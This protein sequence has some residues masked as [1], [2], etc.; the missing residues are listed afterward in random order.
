MASTTLSP[1]QLQALFDILNHHESYHEV[2]GFKSSQSLRDFGYPLN[3]TPDFERGTS[4]VY[5]SRSTSPLVQLLV[6]RCLLTFPGMSDLPPDF[7]PY[8]VQ[9]IITR[10][11]EGNLSESYD[12]SRLGIRKTLATGGSVILEALTRGLLGGVPDRGDKISLKDRRYDMTQAAELQRAW[13]DCMQGLVYGD[14]ADDM[15]D[16]FTKTADL[17]AHSAA[18]SAASEYAILHLASLLHHVFVLSGEGQYLLGLIEG[19]VKLIPFGSVRTV[20]RIGNAATMINGIIK[21]FLAKMSIGA[22]M[23]MIG[24]SAGDA[25]G[26]MNMLQR[27][28]SL[29][30]D[31]D[32]GDF[33][34]QASKIESAKDAPSQQHLALLKEY[35]SLPIETQRAMR[36]LSTATQKSIVAV[37][38]DASDPSLA[39]SLT[40]AQHARCMEWLSAMLSVRDREQGI[41]VL[42]NSSPDHFT[43]AVRALV[44]AYEPFIRSIH[45]SVDLS[46]H[47]TAAETFM[48][49]FIETAKPK[50]EK[51]QWFSMYSSKAPGEEVQPPSV[52]DFASLLQR[53]K[54]LLYAYCHAFAKGCP[55]LVELMRGWAKTSLAEFKQASGS[56]ISDG[57]G[58][59]NNRLQDLYS[60]VP[61]EV[62]QDVLKKLDEHSAYLSR[63]DDFSTSRMQCILH[64][65]AGRD[66]KVEQKPEKSRVGRS[67]KTAPPTTQTRCAPSMS[68]PGVY[69][70]RWDALLDETLIT[71][72][73]VNGAV[74]YGKDV[75]GEN[76]RPKSEDGKSSWDISA[77]IGEEGKQ[78]PNAPDVGIVVQELG[79]KFRALVVDEVGKVEPTTDEKRGFVVQKTSVGLK[80]GLEALPATA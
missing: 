80:N 40:A 56:T 44:N 32:A 63:L 35:L 7:W 60:Q 48:A 51:K 10:L 1:P 41:E 25:D 36:E 27:I 49:D 39:S 38:L 15:F 66:G 3:S 29:V 53:N 65:L 31:W 13:D 45:A 23:N 24:L 42:C 58:A 46:K 52:E 78:L 12:K 75:K 2:E 19:V 76:G 73:T 33:R 62:Q 16:Y 64:G 34:K 28:L 43:T 8:N 67:T 61:A 54:G 47:V 72:A 26:G 9:S 18:V 50:V 69:I 5:Q 59:M 57:A 70:L 11:C 21:L 37:I 30:M 14:L 22:M 71:P 74:R 68:G 55:D 17:E 20:L 79:G 6:T 77:I 4:A